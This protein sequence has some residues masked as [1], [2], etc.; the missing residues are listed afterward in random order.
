M[1]RNINAKEIKENKEGD[2]EKF[3]WFNLQPKSKG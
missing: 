1:K 2:K 3:T